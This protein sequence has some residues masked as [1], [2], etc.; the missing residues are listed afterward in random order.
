[1]VRGTGAPGPG[2]PRA[3]A[4]RSTCS[5]STRPL[6]EGR[7]V[8]LHRGR[9]AAP[10]VRDGGPVPAGAR[11]ERAPAGHASGLPRHPGYTT[12]LCECGQ[13]RERQAARRAAAAV[14]IAVRAA[15][16]MREEDAPEAGRARERLRNGCA[17]LP[18]LLE[19]VYRH[20]FDRTRPL[21][22]TR[23]GFRQLPARWRR[24]EVIGDD[25]HGEVVAPKEGMLLM[26]LTSGWARTASS[27]CGRS[28]TSRRA[29][30]SGAADTRRVTRDGGK[31]NV[32]PHLGCG[33]GRGHR[34]GLWRGGRAAPRRSPPALATWRPTDEVPVVIAAP[35][36]AAR[37]A[38]AV[39]TGAA[40]GQEPRGRRAHDQREVRNPAGPTVLP[41]I[42][43][44]R[45]A[46]WFRRTASSTSGEARASG[47]QPL[48]DYRPGAPLLALAGSGPGGAPPAGPRLATFSIL[49]RGGAARAG[50][51]PRPGAGDPPGDGVGD[52]LARG[53]TPGTADRDPCRDAAAGVATS[54]P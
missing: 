30:R 5:T 41:G 3:G 19:T 26:P 47:K 49:T 6:R 42:V 9:P 7:H 11:S 20:P 22:S 23:P 4:D 14:W 1:M 52:W 46:A 35:G 54:I 33:G 44:L 40:L 24:G 50:V 18:R 13:H 16:L 25:R 36:G 12:M 45:G 53:T 32:R 34:R 8:H 15:G 39:G 29:P 28:G 37:R 38:D 27:W 10:P 48:P 2:R 31:E 17:R 43:S 21:R 51:A